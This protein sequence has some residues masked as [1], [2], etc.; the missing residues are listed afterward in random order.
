MRHLA[1]CFTPPSYSCLA[2]DVHQS[3]TGMKGSDTPLPN[4]FYGINFP[5]FACTDK[6]ATFIDNTTFSGTAD[7]IA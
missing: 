2:N 1:A 6:S 4:S 3:Q 5:N 7:A